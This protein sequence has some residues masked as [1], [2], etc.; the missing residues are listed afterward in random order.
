MKSGSRPAQNDCPAG[1]LLPGL[2]PGPGLAVP[3]TRYALLMGLRGFVHSVELALRT[4]ERTI[5][6]DRRGR[7]AW[8]WLLPPAIGLA[9]AILS[10]FM[11]GIPDNFGWVDRLAIAIFGFFT[12]TAISFIYLVSFDNDPNQSDDVPQPR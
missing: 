4:F 6:I 1:F 5:G 2:N 11:P 10:L 3:A 8:V 9:V 7:S 12:M